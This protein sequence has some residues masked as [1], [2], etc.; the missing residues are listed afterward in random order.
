MTKGH[1]LLAI[2]PFIHYHTQR[3]N[4]KRIAL[5]LLFAS[6][7]LTAC[8][9]ARVHS[10][11]AK[12]LEKYNDLVRWNDMDRASLF[13]SPAISVE[14]GK[15]ADDAKK[16]K[17]FDYQVLDVKYDEKTREASAVVVYSYYTYTTG[18][19]KKVTDNQKWVYT[20]G[21]GIKGWQLQSPLP[22]FR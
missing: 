4:M 14:F 22:E 6:V 21:D 11:F 12:S 9:G 7:V 20:S 1:A 10:A 18:E 13:A 5:V 3:R 19:V 16:A 8:A 15:R 2:F 17:V